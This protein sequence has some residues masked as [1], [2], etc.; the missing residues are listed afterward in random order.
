MKLDI[1]CGQRKQKGFKGVDIVPGPDID[2]VWDLEKYPWEPFA[3]HSVSEV[4][5][6]HYAEHTSDLMKFMDEVW[7]IC[8]NDAKVTIVSPYYTSLAAWAD[9]TH[10]RVLTE[11]TWAY[12]SKGWREREKLDQYPMKCDFAIGNPVIFFSSPWD[13]KSEEARQ[14]AQQHYWNVVS[15]MVI[16]MRAIK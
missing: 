10:K 15:D 6:A 4:Y 2:F 14:F 1:A 5:I 12:F 11:M 3:D 16:E 13:K 7:R 8:E 9:P